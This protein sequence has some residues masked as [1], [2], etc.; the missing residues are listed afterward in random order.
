M[1]PLLVYCLVVFDGDVALLEGYNLYDNPQWDVE[2][3]G[4]TYF[5]V[6]TSF[7][8]APILEGTLNCVYYST[9]ELTYEDTLNEV[10]L[11]DTF[12]LSS[13]CI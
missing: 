3:E 6:V 2:K 12:L 5:Q 4:D 8:S 7:V 13:I 10:V 1:R 9:S 11:L